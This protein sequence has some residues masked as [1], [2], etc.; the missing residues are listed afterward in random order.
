[1]ALLSVASVNTQHLINEAELAGNVDPFRHSV[2]KRLH[3]HCGEFMNFVGG[4]DSIIR[5]NRIE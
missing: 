1:V 2:L 3:G 5:M 4:V